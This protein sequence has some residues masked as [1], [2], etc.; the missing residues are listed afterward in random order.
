MKEQSKQDVLLEQVEVLI[1]LLARV[2]VDCEQMKII[3][4]L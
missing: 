1:T 4:N 3:I 2:T